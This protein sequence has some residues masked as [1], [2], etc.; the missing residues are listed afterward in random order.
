MRVRAIFLHLGWKPISPSA[1]VK[2]NLHGNKKKI[3]RERITLSQPSFPFKIT[4]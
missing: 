4:A 1:T 3:G 2:E